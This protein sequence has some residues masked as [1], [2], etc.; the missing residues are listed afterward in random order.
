MSITEERL[1][2]VSALISLSLDARRRWYVADTST[3]KD[4]ERITPRSVKITFKVEPCKRRVGRV[5]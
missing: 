4:T 2:Y 5:I 1:D 3:A